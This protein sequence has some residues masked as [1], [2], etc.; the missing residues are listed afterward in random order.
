MR[1]IDAPGT[2]VSGKLSLNPARSAGLTSR[3]GADSTPMLPLNAR[4]NANE[5][6]A[7]SFSRFSPLS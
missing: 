6:P 5:Q 1:N 7:W 3:V 4:H 2:P